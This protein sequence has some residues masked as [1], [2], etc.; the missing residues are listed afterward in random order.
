M[1]SM[2]FKST[3]LFLF[4]SECFFIATQAQTANHPEM[5]KKT[6]ASPE[7]A[8]MGRYG[9]YP[10]SIPIILSY[11]A[12]GN[13]VN[14]YAP[15]VGLG[16]SLN[17]GGRVSRNVMGKDD[18]NFTRSYIDATTIDPY[19]DAD[20]D[21]LRLLA[22]RA[23]DDVEPDIYN[24][25]FPGKSGRFLF[26][27]SS[28]PIMIPYCGVKVAGLNT[29]N[30]LTD[31]FGNVYTF[32]YAD[33]PTTEIPGKTEYDPVSS[34][35]LT[36]MVDNGR[37]DSILF[38]YQSL[39]TG[40]LGKDFVDYVTVDD[41]VTFPGGDLPAYTSRVG[42]PTSYA[43]ITYGDELV[44]SQ[45]TFSQGII[46]FI[47]ST[48]NRLDRSTDSFKS[49][50]SI[51]VYAA[52][53][54]AVPFKTVKFYQSY[55]NNGTDKRLRLDSIRIL[56]KINQVVQRYKFDYNNSI[57]LP[58]IDSKS[59]DLWGYY[60]G[61]FNDVLLPRMTI[62][63]IEDNN[64]P[65]TQRTIGSS[66]AF[67]RDPNP[68]CMQAYILNRITYPTGGYTTFEYETNKYLDG[69]NPKDAGGLRI[70]KIKS[71]NENGICFT[72][73]YKY[74]ANESGFG[75]FNAFLNDF[76]FSTPAVRCTCKRVI[77]MAGQ[78]A[79][80]MRTRTFTS[81]PC[82]DLNPYDGS[83]VV[84]STVTEYI[85]DETNNTGKTIY[86]YS[87]DADN[88]GTYIQIDKSFKTSRS[89]RRA[90]L[91][92]KAV[93]K[94]EGGVYKKVSYLTNTYFKYPTQNNYLSFKVVQRVQYDCD[95]LNSDRDDYGYCNTPV[96]YGDDLL[97]S[98]NEYYYDLNDTNRYVVKSTSYDYNSPQYTQASSITT[99]TS[100]QDVLTTYLKYPTDF[101][102][103]PYSS[104]S[105]LNIIGVP[106]QEDQVLNETTPL[107]SKRSNYFEYYPNFFAIDSVEFKTES[108][109]WE[110]WI[111]YLGYDPSGNLLGAK[112]N[113]DIPTSY[114]YDNYHQVIAEV[115]N[116]NT[117][118]FYFNNFEN[119]DGNS[120]LNDCKTGRKSRTGGFTKSLSDLANGTYNFSWWSKSSGVWSYHQTTEVVSNG[121]FNI[122][123][124]GQ[125]DDV[126][127]Y[128]N[129]S[130]MK[131]YTYDPLVGLTSSTD[132]KSISKYFE[133]DDFGRL[134]HIKDF[135]G[136][137]LNH[138]EYHYKE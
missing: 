84:Y 7:A 78:T 14:D 57:N 131:T 92:S 22:L 136:N 113:H 135:N 107:N 81:N 127:F 102:A 53:D 86:H 130:T 125:I 24:Y 115:T 100:T 126:R 66:N 122:A 58:A 98:T 10:V 83:P 26:D 77:P 23:S 60:N 49:I 27:F 1:N 37:T 111:Y 105:D 109:P 44:P 45:I 106:V 54:L 112:K 11:N 41:N 72:K 97:I 16:W 38:S 19:D 21:K 71:Y 96:F 63:F 89:F 4:F 46:K 59:K 88:L 47:P 90:L 35:L 119:V 15:W 132:E 5:P 69:Q 73:T 134:S 8:A 103:A 104:M 31:E 61:Q 64:G 67:G 32:G 120:N 36:K 65:T 124:S 42:L 74:G 70:S 3:F 76:Y 55:F 87:D 123:L 75:R 51:E 50:D 129:N 39:G 12:S 110:T 33:H 9:E 118:E 34:W 82:T 52:E 25:N 101:A 133:Y 29:P 95:R 68:N 62:Y 56:D 20:F 94:N 137:I 138:Y 40:T 48:A 121:S 91:E 17:A 28:N 13:K 6:P 117:N 80:T 30:K 116:A 99:N 128:I 79:G 108:N 2:N 18:Q 93:Y 85:G 43:I 114:A